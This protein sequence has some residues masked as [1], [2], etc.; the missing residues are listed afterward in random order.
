MKLF[1]QLAAASLIAAACGYPIGCV[2]EE[3]DPANG[4]SGGTAGQ[5]GGAGGQPAARAGRA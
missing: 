4:G 1:R 5:A 2:T 3:D